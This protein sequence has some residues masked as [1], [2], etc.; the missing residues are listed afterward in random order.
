MKKKISNL[1]SKLESTRSIYFNI[2]PETGKF[3]N[4]LIKNRKYQQ[5][6][7]IGT[8]NGYSGIWIAEALSRTG[9]H[10]HT[11]ESHEKKR[12]FLAKEN[13][14]FSDLSEHITLIL[15]HAPKDLP[16]TPKMFDMAFFDATKVEHLSY[17]KAISP[18]IKKGGMIVTDNMISHKKKLKPYLNHIQKKPNWHSH[19]IHIGTGLLISLKK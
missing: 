3:L 1:L 9:G 2:S 13:F 4:L 18:R 12:Y 16:K 8:S 14:K 6:L 15:G 7:E 19:L 11:I 10:L 17:F 5:I